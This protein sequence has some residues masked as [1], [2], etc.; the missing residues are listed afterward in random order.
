MVTSPSQVQ[1]KDIPPHP[2]PLLRIPE[3][4]HTG[5]LSR[6]L[7]DGHEEIAETH[8]GRGHG[9]NRIMHGDASVNFAR[10]IGDRIRA[11]VADHHLFYT[12]HRTA[13]VEVDMA[14]E[15]SH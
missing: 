8:I 10:V 2:E 1:S 14:A 15:I 13:A 12:V 3:L 6:T 7:I 11:A 4:L 5:N 9:C